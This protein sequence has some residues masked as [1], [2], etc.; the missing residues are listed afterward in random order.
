MLRNANM[1]FKKFH[2]LL[3][4]MNINTRI[5]PLRKITW[6]I[7]VRRK[8]HTSSI[9]KF[10]IYIYKH[11]HT[12][13]HVVWARNAIS[14]CLNQLQRYFHHIDSLLK[15]RKIH[16]IIYISLDAQPE[17]I[18][19]CVF[20]FLLLYRLS[21]SADSKIIGIVILSHWS[22]LMQEVWVK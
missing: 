18:L 19:R 12:H 9:I 3:W 11:K 16:Y 7:Q 13:K 4:T 1:I 21:Y 22:N 17:S 8:L 6:I 5:S 2:P 20:F 15:K 14:Y 10:I